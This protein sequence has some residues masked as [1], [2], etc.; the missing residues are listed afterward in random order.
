MLNG[1]FILGV[2]PKNRVVLPRVWLEAVGTEAVLLVGEG[3][4]VRV[5]PACEWRGG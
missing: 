1:Q 4:S 3:R 5:L 2:D